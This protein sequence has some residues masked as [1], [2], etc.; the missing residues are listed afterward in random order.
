MIMFEVISQ[1]ISL[2]NQ[3]Y[4]T[5]EYLRIHLN[6]DNL[7]G[8]A[9]EAQEGNWVKR[10]PLCNRYLRSH[11]TH[12]EPAILDFVVKCIRCEK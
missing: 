9:S 7:P 12:L 6:S 5:A 10:A 8:P 3:Y 2:P 11:E 4:L 1:Q